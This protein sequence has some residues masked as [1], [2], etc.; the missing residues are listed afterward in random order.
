VTGQVVTG[1]NK[2]LYVISDATAETAERVLR[3]ALIQFREARPQIRIFS[4]LRKDEQIEEALRLA[5]IDQALVLYTIVNP[6]QRA[7]LEAKARIY[8]LQTIDLIGHLMGR[9]ATFLEAEPTGRPGLGQL[10]Q[11]YFDR[12]EA[13]EFAVK[14]DDG[15]AAQ[16]L[17][18]ADVVLVGLSRTSKTPL[19]TYLAQRGLK[20]AN[21][22]VVLGLPLPRE[23]DQIEQAKIFGLTINAGALIR[24][25]RAR[26]RALN[27]PDDTDYARR[28]HIVREL[29]YARDL[30]AAHPLWPVID[31]SERA[32]EE[33]AA[34]LLRIREQR[35]RGIMEP[36][37]R[38]DLVIP[39]SEI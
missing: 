30:F 38:E 1:G 16:G 6:E 36:I 25:R 17:N 19:S 33:S 20:V 11:A 34:I 9:L 4:L 2:F 28:D 8:H 12:I 32:I 13:V 26:L 21:V 3:A 22:P 15:Q 27:M 10:N 39:G 18:T 37:A 31:V 7:M 29:Q 5:A 23:L 24:I 35:L 14:H